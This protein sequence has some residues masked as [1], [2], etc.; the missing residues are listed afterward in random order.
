[1]RLFRELRLP[2]GRLACVTRP[3]PSEEDF[4]GHCHPEITEAALVQIGKGSIFGAPCEIQYR[5]AEHLCERIPSLQYVRYCNSGTEASLFAL[6]AA[7]AFTGKDVVMKMDGGYHG[8][9][10][11]AVVNGVADTSTHRQPRKQVP[12]GV[13][14]CTG[15]GVL[16]VPFN[17]LE[18]TKDIIEENISQLAAIIVEP[19]MGAA[20][21][22]NPLPQYLKGLRELAN[23]YQLVLI[24]DEIITFRLDWKGIQGRERV[25]PDITTLGKLIG[26]GFP[27]GAFGGRKEI[28]DVF[29]PG[30]SDAVT[31]GGTFNGHNVALAAG[32]VGLEMLNQAAISRINALGNQMRAGYR[33]AL[34]KY[35]VKGQVTGQG[36]LLGLHWGSN[37]PITARDSGLVSN[38]AGDLPKLFHL[39]MM[40]SGIY[41][42]PRG[43][44]VI[45][46]PM[47]ELEIKASIEAFEQ[48]LELLKP[49]IASELPNLLV[50]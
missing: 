24:F 12:R 35:G 36:S 7:R 50:S 40:N 39:Q 45:S 34:E 14:A 16:V 4:H 41:S 8:T 1:M 10:D 9:H 37:V 28:M 25:T 26:G 43:M 21:L 3:C 42:A 33:N 22:I 23:R 38:M 32:L 27:V 6:R 17:D 44:Y 15:Y 48:T 47:T 46:T 18:V 30:H 31:H 5:H 11:V 49:Y 2:F 19:V 29:N 20:G 13:S